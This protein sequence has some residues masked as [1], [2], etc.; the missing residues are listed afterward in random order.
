MSEYRD[1]FRPP[2]SQKEFEK[3]VEEATGMK[4]SEIPKG[5]K[6][7]ASLHKLAVH[8]D[9]YVVGYGQP[10]KDDETGEETFSEFRVVDLS[11][12]KE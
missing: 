11:D 3:R 5:E 2:E 4:L 1:G 7:D 6:N 12:A 9:V 8:G 10:D